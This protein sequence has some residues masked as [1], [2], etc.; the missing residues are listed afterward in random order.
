MKRCFSVN[1]RVG[2]AEPLWLRLRPRAR[3]LSLRPTRTRLRKKAAPASSNG[4][5]PSLAEV[6]RVATLQAEQDLI[7]PTLR[8]VQWNRRKAAPLLGIS[9]KTLLNKIKE[10]GIVQE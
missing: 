9:Y 5:T 7:I 10:H 3:R 2:T 8:R 4:G 1:C 6:A